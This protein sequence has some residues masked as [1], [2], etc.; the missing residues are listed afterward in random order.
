MHGAPVTARH[1]EQFNTLPWRKTESESET[2]QP[3][4]MEAR[5]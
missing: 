3:M 4:I 2:S 1:Q 5:A